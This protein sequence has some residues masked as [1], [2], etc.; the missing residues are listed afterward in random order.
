[1]ENDLK[2]LFNRYRYTLQTKYKRQIHA[3]DKIQEVQYYIKYLHNL[4]EFSVI[5]LHGLS[6]TYTE[7]CAIYLRTIQTI[8]LYILFQI[9]LHI[10]ERSHSTI[11]RL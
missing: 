1:M 8:I 11:I 10:A 4:S 2:L 5:I 7:Y 9:I 3:T 6:Y